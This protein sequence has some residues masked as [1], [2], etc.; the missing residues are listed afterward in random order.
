M[1][2][3][4]MCSEDFPYM[5]FDANYD[6]TIMGNLMLQAIQHQCALW[7]RGEVPED[8]HDPVISDVPVLLMAG[9]RDPVTPPAYAAQAAQNFTNSANL[10]A[11]GQSHSVLRNTC[12]QQVVT[13]F[14]EQG[15]VADLDTSCVDDIQPSPFF[16]SLLG[17]EP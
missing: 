8:F 2:A 4:V 17:P 11:R 9:E 6:D 15:S 1:E 12:L 3:S 5:D 13:H 10:V 7:P 14:I 16:T